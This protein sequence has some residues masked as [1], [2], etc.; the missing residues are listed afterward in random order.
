MGMGLCPT[1]ASRAREPR[2]YIGS[3][4]P[5][6]PRYIMV[7]QNNEPMNPFLGWIHWFFRCATSMYDPSDHRDLD[8]PTMLIYM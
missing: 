3:S 8:H 2:Y 4:E 5:R 7:H 6:S 1:R